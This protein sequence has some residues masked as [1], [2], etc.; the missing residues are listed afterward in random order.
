MSVVPFF[1]RRGPDDFFAALSDALAF[2][3]PP[4]PLPPSMAL[5]LSFG[6]SRVGNSFF[7]NP[8]NVLTRK[9]VR[10]LR[11]EFEPHFGQILRK[12]LYFPP[13]VTVHKRTLW[14]L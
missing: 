2:L 8:C 10:L 9:R 3:S 12:I 14:W 11:N 6:T 5:S 4:P 7:P 13:L 1:S